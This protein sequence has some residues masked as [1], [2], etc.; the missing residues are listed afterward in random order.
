VT[1]VS[2]IE[3][4]SGVPDG[5]AISIGLPVFNGER[6]LARAIESLLEQSFAD[7]ELI[8]SDNASTDDTR[9][10]CLSYARQ[11]DR[12]RYFRQPVNVG[13]PR[14][15]SYVSTLAGGALFKW[16]SANDVSAPRMLEKCHRALVEF[17]SAVLSFG[18][19]CLVDEESE[20]QDFYAEDFSIL[21]DSPSDRLARLL[22]ELRLNN[23]QSGLIR[24]AALRQTGLDR[25]YPGG[26]MPL[27][28]ELVLR[29]K[30]LLLPDVLHYRRVGPSTFSRDLADDAHRNFYGM[31]RRVLLDELMCR[32]DMWV[33]M[34]RAP[35]SIAEKC[36][37]SQVLAR[38]TWWGALGIFRHWR[39]A[40]PV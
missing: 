7:F 22:G 23:P 10:I 35:I 38:H 14:N 6:F 28:V 25:P 13:A 20:R 11:D 8:I 17:P 9:S 26:D 24:L 18:R 36:R 33:G 5:P 21:D 31:S 32:R 40:L 34:I 4:G 12:I 29:G 1:D 16:A 27:M 3:P 30:F 15:W 19:T 37:A 2:F 39:S